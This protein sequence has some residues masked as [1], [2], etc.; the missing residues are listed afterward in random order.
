MIAVADRQIEGVSEARSL[1]A[2]GKATHG[3]HVNIQEIDGVLLN[4][5]GQLVEILPLSRGDWNT[6]LFAKLRQKMR[7]VVHDRLLEPHQVVRLKALAPA[8]SGVEFHEI[9]RAS[10][11]E[12]VENSVVDESSYKKRIEMS[13]L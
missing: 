9:G 13:I 7:I 10:C 8:H 6:R 3:E 5:V 4:Q 12:R 11:R 1:H 2:H